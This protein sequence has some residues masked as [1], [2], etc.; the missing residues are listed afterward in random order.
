MLSST[1][2][3]TRPPATLATAA[4]GSRVF[5]N[6]K[7]HLLERGQRDSRRVLY[8]LADFDALSLYLRITLAADGRIA[9]VQITQV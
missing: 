9:R 4:G 6:L 2:A 7:L 1:C 3:P 5:A 8:Y